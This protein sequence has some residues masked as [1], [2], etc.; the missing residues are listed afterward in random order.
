MS[1]NENVK[2]NR[3]LRKKLYLGEFTVYG[4]DLSFDFDG[5]E[6]QGASD[7]LDEIIE[8]VES[9]DLII[10]G[11][12]DTKSFGLFICAAARY[13]SATE[14]DRAALI[15]WLEAKP[16]VKEIVAGELVNAYYES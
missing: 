13:A 1:N 7:F 3:R 5:M 16:V 12:G 15:S 9:R 6:P 11:G 14:E 4:F 10:A 8:L 2:Q